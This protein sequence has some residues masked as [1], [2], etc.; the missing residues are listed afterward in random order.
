MGLMDLSSSVP[1]QTTIALYPGDSLHYHNRQTILQTR[2]MYP[3]L[4]R[5]FESARIKKSRDLNL[6]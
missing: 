1:P 4:S 2:V 5:F 6:K 3:L